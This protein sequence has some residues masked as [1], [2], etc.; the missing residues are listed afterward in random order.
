M[1]GSS[2]RYSVRPGDAPAQLLRQL[3]ALGFAARERGGG[4]PELEIAQADIGQH[5]QARKRGGDI[6]EQRQGF[7]DC[8]VE[9][10]GNIVIAVVHRERLAGE[11]A[12]V[13]GRAA[14]LHVGQELH[15]HRQNAG[16]F[17]ALAAPTRHIEREVPG[18]QPKLG[19]LLEWP[20]RPRGSG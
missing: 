5:L 10:L 17:A 9:H 18:G 3:H 1:V 8:H 20:Q 6:R 11:A 15:L 14:H 7:F 16:A 13:T 2:S 4:L 12:S 19:E